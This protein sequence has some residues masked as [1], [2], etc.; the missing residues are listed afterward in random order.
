MTETAQSNHAVW[1]SRARLAFWVFAV[2]GAFLLIAEH[3]AH[4]LPFL[5]WLLLA[6]CPL[7]H[8]FMHG[9]HGLHRAPR[10]GPRGMSR[11][12]RELAAETGDDRDIVGRDIGSVNGPSEGGR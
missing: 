4:V 2:I 12:P 11:S 10:N 3:R 9:G 7:M 1:A 8:F 5:P 6:A